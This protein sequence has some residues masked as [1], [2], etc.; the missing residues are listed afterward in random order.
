MKPTGGWLRQ[1]ERGLEQARVSAHGERHSWACVDAQQ[2]AEKAV[3]AVHLSLGQ[4]PFGYV[5]AQLLRDLPGGV[6]EKLVDKALALD[7]LSVPARHREQR[8]P[9]AVHSKQAISYAGEIIDFV[10]TRLSES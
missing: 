3:K 7:S 10:R 9:S 6:P 2:A 5:I 8:M 4:E 1:A